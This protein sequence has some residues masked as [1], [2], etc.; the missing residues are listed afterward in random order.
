[1][2]TYFESGKCKAAKGEGWAL[3]S[4]CCAKTKVDFCPPTATMA[5][6][7]WEAFTFLYIFHL[8]TIHEHSIGTMQIMSV[9]MILPKL[10]SFEF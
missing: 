1:M 10:L 6:M 3:P 7:L 5:I 2:G 8:A 4:F 9:T